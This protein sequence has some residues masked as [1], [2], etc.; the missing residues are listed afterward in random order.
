MSGRS[1]VEIV[2]LRRE[3]T[4]IANTAGLSKRRLRNAARG[5]YAATAEKRMAETSES[6]PIQTI[7]QERPK[8]RLQVED[9]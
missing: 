8:A 3:M 9:W 1:S 7:Q 6:V 5:I 2:S 4:T